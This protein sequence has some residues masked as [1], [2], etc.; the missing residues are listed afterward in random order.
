[1]NK[2]AVRTITCA[3]CGK[4]VTKR[5]PAGRQFCSLECYRTSARPQRMTGKTIE[6]AQCGTP[7]YMPVARLEASA[8]FCSKAC[9]NEWQ[10]R[11]K[12]EHTC[13]MC[14][15]TFRWSPS[16]SQGGHYNIT[17]CSLAC[18]DADPERAEMLIRIN[19]RQQELSP[20][21][22]E[23]AGYAILDSLRLEYVKQHVIS[24][25]FTV[26]AFV[27]S[28]SLVIQFDGDY[29]HGHPERFP[30]P[31]PRQQRRMAF[32]KSQD[33]YMRQCG[34]TVLRFWETAVHRQPEAVR[35]S[36]AALNA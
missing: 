36:I 7:V 20:N 8:R 34:L 27:P 3:A 17:Y 1:M 29:W 31:D 18:R 10:G 35:Q 21:K 22:L 19:Q 24:G 5:M 6:C 16:R 14:G 30:T 28:L 9:A 26:D 23:R 4:T 33:A 11:N 12:T 32:D 25:K 15:G 2:Y 13:K